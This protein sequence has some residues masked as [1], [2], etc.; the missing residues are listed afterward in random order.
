IWVGISYKIH[1]LYFQ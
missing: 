1:S